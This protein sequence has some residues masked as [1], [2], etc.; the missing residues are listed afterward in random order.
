MIIQKPWG[1]EEIIEHNN[2]YVV[3]RLFMKAGHKCSL[4]YHNEKHETFVVLSGKLK[5]Y[6]G[7]DIDSIEEKILIPGDY[8]VV[9]PKLIHRM[10]GIEDSL[11]LEASTS[12]LDDVVRLKDEYNR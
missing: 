4:Q 12:Q 11:Y 10:E 6:V 5:F 2:N 9:P 8:Y 1:H 7:V 3:K